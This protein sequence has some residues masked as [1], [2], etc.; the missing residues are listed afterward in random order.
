MN[1]QA[2]VDSL[3]HIDAPLYASQIAQKRNILA[4][5]PA[6]YFQC[7]PPAM[8]L[9]WD[10]VELLLPDMARAWPQDFTLQT[11]GPRWTWTNRLLETTTRFAPGDPETLPCPALEW[12]GRQVQEDLLLMGTAPDGASLLAGGLLCFASGWCLGDKMGK[13]LLA[14]HAEVPGFNARIG[15]PT[16]LLLRRLKAGRP[17][18]R[19][20]WSFSP[21][22]Q[23]NLSPALA[24]GWKPCRDTVTPQNAGA[25]CF[26]RVERQ[27]LSRLPRTGGILF[28][29]H[30]SLKAVG[31][32]DPAQRRALA[33][34]IRSIP[35]ETLAYKGMMPYADALLTY[36]DAA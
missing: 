9:A 7:P 23:L 16:D 13:P 2:G 5:D 8:P 31:E 20:N 1:A 29:V 25:R 12:L 11:N 21:T 35:V 36:L 22:L 15:P 6:Y 34:F 24:G 27:T 10:A 19:L 28:T 18:A 30:T 26:V 4:S 17:V 3:I 32:A 33:S 14:I